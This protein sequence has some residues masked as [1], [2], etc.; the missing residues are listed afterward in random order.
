MTRRLRDV[1]N[2]IGCSEGRSANAL[3]RSHNSSRSGRRH[4]PPKE[5]ILFLERLRLVSEGISHSRSTSVKRLCERLR[6]MRE[7]R[8]LGLG[9]DRGC[10]MRAQGLRV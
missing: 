3:S 6:L 1:R 8:G 7:E 4:K 10:L 5:D 2:A 9:E